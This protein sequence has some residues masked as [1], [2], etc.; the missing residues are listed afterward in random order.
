MFLEEAFMA[1]VTITTSSK[2]G[3]GSSRTRVSIPVSRTQ[4]KPLPLQRVDLVA[5]NAS[6][7]QASETRNKLVDKLPLR[8][9]S[10]VKT[11]ELRYG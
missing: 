3:P 6:V 2:V 9:C 1:N 11:G 7:C 4:T 5:D 8:A 10:F